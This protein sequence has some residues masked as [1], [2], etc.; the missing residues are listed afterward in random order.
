MHWQTGSNALKEIP[1]P[2]FLA[3]INELGGNS[4]SNARNVYKKFLAGKSDQRGIDQLSNLVKDVDTS[5]LYPKT[6]SQYER[7]LF[8]AGKVVPCLRND[9]DRELSSDEQKIIYGRLKSQFES[10]NSSLIKPK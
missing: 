3:K 9:D 2:I 1:A 7:T 5:N 6:W 8:H 4:K 10:E